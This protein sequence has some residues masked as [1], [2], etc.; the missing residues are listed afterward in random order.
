M[1]DPTDHVDR[2]TGWILNW[3]HVILPCLALAFVASFL[4]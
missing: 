3:Q 4:I 1:T 2:F